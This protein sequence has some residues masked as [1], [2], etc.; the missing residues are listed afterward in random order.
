MSGSP[1][2][3]AACSSGANE[4]SHVLEAMGLSAG[5]ARSSVRFSLH[6]QTTEEEIDQTIELVAAQV[7]R[8]R[9]LSAVTS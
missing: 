4:P 9:E 3:N 5:Q 7:A 8:L 1:P 6:R 2:K